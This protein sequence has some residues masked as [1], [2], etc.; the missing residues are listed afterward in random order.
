MAPSQ[1]LLK[2]TVTSVFYQA[3]GDCCAAAADTQAALDQIPSARLREQRG[4]V[5]KQPNQAQNDHQYTNRN[6]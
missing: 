3:S 6:H 5:S 2:L 4:E 1:R